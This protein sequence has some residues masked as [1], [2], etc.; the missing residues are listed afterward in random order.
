MAR[1]NRTY[2]GHWEGYFH[3]PE[4]PKP[5]SRWRWV[6]DAVLG[7]AGASFLGYSMGLLL[8]I[9]EWSLGGSA[10]G[11]LGMLALS[12]WGIT[13]VVGQFVDSARQSTR[14]LVR[15]A[16]VAVGVFLITGVLTFVRNV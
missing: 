9:G 1:D 14:D 15:V 5:P 8:A 2:S 4:H 10:A 13:V 11:V 6:V 3:G 16:V 12:L 7:A